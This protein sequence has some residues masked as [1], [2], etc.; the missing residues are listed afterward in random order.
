M[1]RSMS[2]RVMCVLVLTV[3][4]CGA[5]GPVESADSS[6]AD[7]TPSTVAPDRSTLS[8][9]RDDLNPVPTTRAASEVVPGT[10]VDPGLRGLADIAIADLASELEVPKETIGLVSAE[11]VTWPNAALGCPEPGRSYPDGPIDGSRIVLE[12]AG[13]LYAYHTGGDRWE[14]FLCR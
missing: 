11:L 14:P 6:E 2:I 4:A 1:I 5:G 13:D 9:T 3:T 8:I 12:H 10:G 7:S